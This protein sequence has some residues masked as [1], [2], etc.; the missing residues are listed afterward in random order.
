MRNSIADVLLILLILFLVICVVISFVISFVSL[1]ATKICN[2]NGW[3]RALTY[4]DMSSYC[5]REINETEYVCHVSAVVAN[6]CVFDYN[7]E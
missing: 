2:E 3:P 4:P 5:V 1:R 7:T 6:G